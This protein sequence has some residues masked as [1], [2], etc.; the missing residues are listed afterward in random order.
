MTDEFTLGGE[1]KPSLCNSYMVHAIYHEVPSAAKILLERG[2]CADAII[3]RIFQCSYRD[4]SHKLDCFSTFTWLTLSVYLGAASSPEVLILHGAD[5]T[6]LDAGL[7]SALRL[8]TSTA[9]RPYPR[10]VH[11][12]P[13]GV[14]NNATITAE[15]DMKTLA[16]VKHAFDLKYGGTMSMEEYIASNNQPDMK[17]VKTAVAK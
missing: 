4:T 9:S 12:N 3:G 2:D 15:A 13:Y 8:V 10:I 17:Q 14:D 5:V 1:Q 11:S 16:V 7:R 6:M